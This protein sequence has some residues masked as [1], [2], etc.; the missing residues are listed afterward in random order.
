MA[1]Y[2]FIPTPLPEESP[3]SLL[4]RMASRHGCVIRE[5][6]RLLFK[7]DGMYQTILSR[8]H[9]VVQDIAHDPLTNAE[10]F[11]TGFYEPIGP[12][13]EVPPLK[14]AGLVIRADMIR[15]RSAAF[16]SECWKENHERFIK[17]ITWAIYC[18]YH[19]R[20][21]LE[22]CPTCGIR[23]HWATLLP[24]TCRCN[25]LPCS[26]TCTSSDAN[27]ELK[28]LDIFR[29]SDA[30]KLKKLEQ[31]L[32]LLGHRV[33]DDN[34][35]PAVRTTFNLAFALLEGD[36]N[37]VLANISYLCDLYPF[38]PRRIICAK[39]ASIAEPMARQCVIQF[40]RGHF[41][42]TPGPSPQV[43]IT[44][45][46]LTRTQINDWLG[47]VIHRGIITHKTSGLPRTTYTYRFNWTQAQFLSEHTLRLKLTNGYS[48]KKKFTGLIIK[49]V[50][51]L[52]LLSA[53]S[54][55]GL[56]SEKTLTPLTGCRSTLLFKEPE[57]LSFSE[58]YTSIKAMCVETSISKHRIR[59]ALKELN[60]I[61][62]DFS[63]TLLNQKLIRTEDKQPVID[64]C[65][66][67]LPRRPSRGKASYP[68]LST[69]SYETGDWFSTFDAA[70]QL[71]ISVHVIRFLIRARLI[72]CQQRLVGRGPAFF[73][74]KAEIERFE[75]DYIGVTDAA[76]LLEC[77][78]VNT[79]KLLMNNGLS[80]VTGP[81]VDENLTFF[82]RRS[83]VI[84]F[85]TQRD[86]A[87]IINGGGL[88][89]DETKKVLNISTNAVLFLIQTNILT[90][91]NE[92]DKTIVKEKVEHF[93]SNYAERTTIANWLRIPKTCVLKFLQIYNIT[94]LTPSFR[95]ACFYLID[96]IARHFSIPVRPD[97][98]EYPIISTDITKASDVRD[99]YKCPSAIFSKLFI[100]SGYVT[101]IQDF[102][103]LYITKADE[104]RV[105]NILD[106]YCTMSQA[107]K[108]LGLRHFSGNLV[109][110]HKLRT[111][112][113][114]KPYSDHPMLKRA[115]LYEYARRNNIR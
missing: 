33:G 57:V 77:P 29:A 21:Y 1:R 42:G 86:N 67:R 76:R 40:L 114:L 105:A 95:G 109:R 55:R 5:D 36:K 101:T 22:R 43:C 107:D 53:Q 24:G 108:Y 19:L 65:N 56:I 47:L 99:K 69:D 31:N 80:P 41:H 44:P 8:S 71:K 32:Y 97:A 115:E 30:E 106:K 74:N 83:D 49:Q 81:G 10:E 88:T 91:R 13:P 102:G 38:V 113:P 3:S 54:I 15:K 73:I 103:P 94:P 27:I 25:T 45:F 79:S 20:K 23:L 50:Q 48:K 62:L 61:R 59:K 112:H 7:F 93:H 78:L 96:D 64:W 17:D 100:T 6:L 110:T 66:T 4:R 82:F 39:L 111:L 72:S 34:R 84:N 16:C 2:L 14:I 104:R 18:P 85:M 46:S 89:I 37:A 92:V 12:L 70:L 90:W 98:T 63:N 11:L 9:Q 35:C 26:P 75:K 68:M 52:L 28:L 87:R 60:L 51:Q 58:R